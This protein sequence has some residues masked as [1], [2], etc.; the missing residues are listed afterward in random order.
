MQ[1][2]VVAGF[3]VVMTMMPIRAP[4]P[5]WL[6]VAGAFG[7][8]GVA[9]LLTR[10]LVSLG[11][12]Q[13]LNP[14]GAHGWPGRAVGVLAAGTQMYLVAGL[15]ALMALGW[16]GV[17]EDTFR[18]GNIPLLGKAVAM[19][20]FAAALTV[21]WWAIAPLDQAMRMRLS[22]DQALMGRPVLPC[23]SRRQHLS[24]HVRHSLLFIAVP[25]AGIVAVLDSFSLAENAG[26]IAPPASTVAAMLGCSAVFLLA[27]VAIVRIWRARP[28][29]P[30]ALRTR[31]EA[32]C[33]DLKLKYRD[34]MVWRT[35]G[36]VANA[37]V[38]GLTGRVRYVLLSDGLL[39]SL[40]E[41]QVRAIFAHE[42]GHV[43]HQHI[44]YMVLFTVA[45]ATV[46]YAAGADVARWLW[47]G[48]VPMSAGVLGVPLIAVGW[49]LTFGV[50]IRRFERQADVFA[51]ATVSGEEDGGPGTLTNRGVDL[52][53]GALIEVARLNAISL[54]RRNFR[55]GSIRRRVRY[56][57]GLLARGAGPAAIDH[58]VALI[59]AGI[60][61]LLAVGVALA[62]VQRV[63]VG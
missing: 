22:Q 1:I 11:M 6:P 60:W 34:I 33:R 53:S 2:L 47:P 16:G 45:T 49:I 37:G 23:W 52:F 19:A 31:L 9:H 15:A 44:P 29:P 57:A 10:L 55:H 20:P 18:L 27:P 39:D 51:A 4:A 61:A 14:A 50:L 38:M 42:A 46:L 28:L 43:V 12:R 24:F 32:T 3:V 21:H 54:S 62:V 25:A 40:D 26:W 7:Y 48:G 58:R 17:V 35:G 36:V 13:V 63:G 41:D 59:K 56:L 8:V 5:W 30:G